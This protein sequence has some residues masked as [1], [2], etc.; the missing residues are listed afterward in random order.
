MRFPWEYIVVAPLVALLASPAEAQPGNPPNTAG[1]FAQPLPG[2]A[3]GLRPTNHPASQVRASGS[4]QSGRYVMLLSSPS[5]GG[6]RMKLQ[7]HILLAT[8][9][10]TAAG[11]S[12]SRQY[13]LQA[14]FVP[15]AAKTMRRVRPEPPS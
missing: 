15:T 3:R 1:A 6:A 11:E 7:Q 14:G 8:V 12:S 10:Q 2:A 4:M 9:G 5:I 13:R